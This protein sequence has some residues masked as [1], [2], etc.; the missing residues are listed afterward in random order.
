MPPY[1]RL[2]FGPGF[3][4]SDVPSE[5]RIHQHARFRIMIVPKTGVQKK[6]QGDASYC[7]GPLG[8]I[9][10]PQKGS[11]PRLPWTGAFP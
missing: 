7:S 1:F 8:S 11:P 9:D 6:V 10:E 5:T 3:Q 4:R 2:A